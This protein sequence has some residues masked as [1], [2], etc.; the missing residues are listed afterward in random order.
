MTVERKIVFALN[1]IVNISYE[2][3]KC[4]A[5][6]T[7]PLG[8]ELDAPTNCYNCKNQWKPQ[9]TGQY[10][11]RNDETSAFIELLRSINAIR[12][13]EAQKVIGFRTIFELNELPVSREVNDRV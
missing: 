13:L 4:G 11:G 12:T 9:Q 2:C 8:A 10:F 1:D 6:V 3:A 7:F 5:R